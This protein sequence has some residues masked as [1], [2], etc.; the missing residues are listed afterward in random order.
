MRIKN[1]LIK[2]DELL[3]NW[4]LLEKVIENNSKELL[5]LY[6]KYCVKQLI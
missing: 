1:F 3:Y 6:K 2:L 4:T 5:D